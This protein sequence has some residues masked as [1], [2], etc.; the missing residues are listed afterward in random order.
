[1]DRGQAEKRCVG[2]VGDVD[3]SIVTVARPGDKTLSHCETTLHE[4]AI[5]I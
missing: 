2:A 4:N 5:T 1:M 3:W